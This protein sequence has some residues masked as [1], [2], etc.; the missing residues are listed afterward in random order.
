MLP[1]ANIIEN[2][3]MYMISSLFSDIPIHEKSQIARA[4]FLIH[5]LS[6]TV[7]FFQN[8]NFYALGV[9]LTVKEFYGKKTILENSNIHVQSEKIPRK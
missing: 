8:S 4:F 9:R 2:H 5:H 1:F 6:F 3:Y 7:F